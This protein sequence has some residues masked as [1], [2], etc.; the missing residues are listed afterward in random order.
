MGRYGGGGGHYSNYTQQVSF[1]E[2]GRTDG[3]TPDRPVYYKLT[4]SGEL[5]TDVVSSLHWS[6]YFK[7]P[8]IPL[9]HSLT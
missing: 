9:S 5:K 3:R 8:H 4:L 1:R 6:F 7:P 2:P